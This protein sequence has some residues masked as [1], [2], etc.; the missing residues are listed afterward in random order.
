MTKPLLAAAVAATALFLSLP[1]PALAQTQGQQ[2]HHAQGQ[3]NPAAPSADVPGAATPG[4]MEPGMMQ[5]RSQETM[6][7][8]TMGQMMGG[9]MPDG[10]RM[11]M[12]GAGAGM[13]MDMGSAGCP[14]MAQMMRMH[15]GMM[16][17]MHGGMGSGSGMMGRGSHGAMMGQRGGQALT[18]MGGDDTKLDSGIVTPARHLSPDDVRDYFTHR[19]QRIGND[20]LKLGDITQTDPDSITIEILTQD[21]SLVDRL[22]VDR[23]SGEIERAG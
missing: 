22:N 15:P 7:H 18:M 20:R 16:S 8:G 1:H 17:M 14:M 5:T 23:H 19:L 3:G 6:P 12:M 11:P 10:A 2:Q 4:P 9:M 13:G 21:G